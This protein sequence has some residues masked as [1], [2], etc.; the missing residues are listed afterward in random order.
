[1]TRRA[2][3]AVALFAAVAPAAAQTAS[4]TAGNVGSVNLRNGYPAGG[5]AVALPTLTNPA[6]TA[7]GAGIVTSAIG[8]D[9]C[10]GGGGVTVGGGGGRSGRGAATGNPTTGAGSG[11]RRAS[12][13][14][15]FLLCP[16]SGASGE[17]AFLLGTD[18]S[19]APQ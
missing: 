8:G 3:L 18:L 2:V 19:C 17:D 12:G 9:G 15:I 1:M 16:P 7:T 14:G 5:G 13:G 11:S 4:P 6:T 10:G